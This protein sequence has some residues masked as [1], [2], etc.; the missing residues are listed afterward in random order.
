[1]DILWHTET[2]LGEID[3]LVIPGGAPFG[4]YIRPGALARLSPVREA[5][6]AFAQRGGLVLGTG[7]GFHVLTE[8]GLL[9]GVLVAN[10]SLRYQCQVE[11]VQV[12][13]A[14]TLFT[15]LWAPGEI[16]KLRI[17]TA[18]GCFQLPHEELQ[19]LEGRGQVVFRYVNCPN[20]SVGGAAGIM[21]EAGNVLGILPQPGHS[22][23]GE[24]LLRS[25]V[26]SVERRMSHGA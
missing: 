3:L 22:P 8:W 21:N 6:L 1:M 14:D 17:S 9:P 25:I 16:L 12:E 11:L 7:S 15:S 18:H 23:D 24:R 13:R 4:N 19:E 5:A 26:Y 20:D 10:P 2:N